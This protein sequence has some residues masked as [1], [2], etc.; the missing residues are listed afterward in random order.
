MDRLWLEYEDQG[1]EGWNAIV[2]EDE[3]SDDLIGG[4][5]FH[6]EYLA[7]TPARL[8]AVNL[9]VTLEAMVAQFG[10]IAQ[11]FDDVEMIDYANSILAACDPDEETKYPTQTMG[12]IE[13]L[14]NI[15]VDQCNEPK[16]MVGLFKVLTD[17]QQIMALSITE[18][19][20]I[21]PQDG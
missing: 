18:N 6:A 20:D 14:V 5:H 2:R 7:A 13:E 3:Y 16:E 1:E 9:K 17:A 10:P 8:Q 15:L 4:S 21:G 12:Y 19:M 11:T